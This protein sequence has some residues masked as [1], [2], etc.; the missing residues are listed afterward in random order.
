MEMHTDFEFHCGT[1][2]HIEPDEL[3]EII[4]GVELR[5]WA[6]ACE[7]ESR[8]KRPDSEQVRL[9]KTW[10]AD[11]KKPRR[12]RGWTLTYDDTEMPF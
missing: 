5:A 7:L 2:P 6:Y 10:K 1:N 8:Y 4:L 9:E 3:A 12:K 11:L